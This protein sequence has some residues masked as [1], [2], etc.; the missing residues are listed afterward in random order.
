MDQYYSHDLIQINSK[1]DKDKRRLNKKKKNTNNNDTLEYNNVGDIIIVNI[2]GGNGHSCAVYIELLEDSDFSDFIHNNLSQYKMI[3]WG[4]NKSG[5]SP[6]E[7]NI[8]SLIN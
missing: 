2:A 3:C 4:E 1:R 8:E 5:Q 6:S 7:I